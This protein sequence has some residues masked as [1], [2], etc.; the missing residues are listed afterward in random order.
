M[1]ISYIVQSARTVEYSNCS[2]AEGYPPP[3]H[4]PNVCPGYDTKQ[5]DCEGPVIL[6]LWRIQSTSSL[7]LLP[8]QRWFGV[9][10]PDRVLSRRQIELNSVLM[11]N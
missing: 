4:T 9:V 7:S 2:S 10:A 8:I 6:E 11:L 3:T 1:T 5:P